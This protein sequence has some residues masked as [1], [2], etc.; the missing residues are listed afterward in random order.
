MYKPLSEH[1]RS[2]LVLDIAD[3][4]WRVQREWA[5]LSPVREVVIVTV[6]GSWLSPDGYVLS[7]YTEHE[8]DLFLCIAGSSTGRSCFQRRAW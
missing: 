2:D 1:G 3:H 5:R 8:V 6:G 7:T 4:L